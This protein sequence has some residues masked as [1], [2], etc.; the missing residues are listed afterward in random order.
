M[1]DFF[2]LVFYSLK[3][4]YHKQ[5]KKTTTP[6]KKFDLTNAKKTGIIIGKNKKRGDIP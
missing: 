1:I 4:L 2:L 5:I 6:Q 3:R